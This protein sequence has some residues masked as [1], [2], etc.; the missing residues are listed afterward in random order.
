MR[1]CVALHDYQAAEEAHLSAQADEEFRIMNSSFAWWLCRNSRGET[2]LLPSNHLKEIDISVRPVSAVS[3]EMPDTGGSG[4][5]SWEDTRPMFLRRRIKQMM[6][7]ALMSD[8]EHDHFMTYNTV[9]TTLIREFDEALYKSQVEHVKECIRRTEELMREKHNSVAVASKEM[10]KAEMKRRHRKSMKKKAKRKQMEDT[11][12]AAASIGGPPWEVD[13]LGAPVGR[14]TDTDD[15]ESSETESESAL[16]LGR[17]VS[18]HLQPS[19]A[20]RSQ[21]KNVGARGFGHLPTVPLLPPR[22]KTQSGRSLASLTGDGQMVAEMSAWQGGWFSKKGDASKSLGVSLP[23]ATKD[24]FF[25]PSQA[26]LKY[27]AKA[28]GGGRHV[29]KGEVGLGLDTT[30]EYPSSRGNTVLITPRG[31]KRTF[32]LTAKDDACFKGMQQYLRMRKNAPKIVGPSELERIKSLDGGHF[33][34]TSLTKWKGGQ[35][36]RKTISKT[37]APNLTVRVC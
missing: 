20:L 29:E 23:S 19:P 36:I 9:K 30:I 2:G 34:N 6:A 7:D 8:D 24:R 37:V 32:D 10:I 1:K 27:Y 15:S 11:V 3:Q 4:R 16:L 18:A 5:A 12:K 13:G 14:G 33:A 22:N 25:V 31:S 35:V 28:T 21:I 17:D 26:G